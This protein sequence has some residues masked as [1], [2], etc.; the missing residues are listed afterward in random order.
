MIKSLGKLS[1]ATILAALVV[2]MP[3]GSFAQDKPTNAPPATPSV[4]VRAIPFRGKLGAVDQV[5]K[6]I[7]LDEKT[8]TNRVFEV[9]SATKITKDGKPATL[10]DGVVGDPVTGS[11]LKGA[12]GKL[13]AKSVI[14][15]TTPAAP[16]QAAPAMPKAVN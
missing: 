13:T 4:A 11:Y 2:G 7:T 10:A 3:M 16:A 8:K 9:T 1:L 15:R 6:T 12:D 14:F 5:N